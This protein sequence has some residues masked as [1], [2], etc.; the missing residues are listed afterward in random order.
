MPGSLKRAA[1]IPTSSG[2]SED[3]LKN[4]SPTFTLFCFSF[5]LILTFPKILISIAILFKTFRKVINFPLPISKSD[6]VF[7]VSPE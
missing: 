3:V 7:P 1:H 4:K 6:F 5:S 2:V